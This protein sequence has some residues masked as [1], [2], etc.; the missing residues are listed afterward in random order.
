ENL[1]DLCQKVTYYL[2]HDQ[3]R[4]QIALAGRERVRRDFTFE[5]RMK[6][7]LKI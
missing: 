5:D 7:M 6:Q 2:A 1:E 3:Q 4:M